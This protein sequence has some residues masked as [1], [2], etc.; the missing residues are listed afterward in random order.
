MIE[1]IKSALKQEYIPFEGDDDLIGV[2][3][4]FP[5]TSKNRFFLNIVQSYMDWQDG[6]IDTPK[7]ESLIRTHLKRALDFRSTFPLQ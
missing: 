5:S 4:I 6:E 2:A 3:D 1:K 7:L